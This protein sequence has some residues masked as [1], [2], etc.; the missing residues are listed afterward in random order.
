MSMIESQQ[1]MALWT[2]YMGIAA[3]IGITVGIIGTGLIFFTFWETRKGTRAA[4]VNSEAYIW[5]ERGRLSF[6]EDKSGPTVIAS[7]K[8][9]R[10]RDPILENTGKS[11]LTLDSVSYA[12]V[13]VPNYDLAEGFKSFDI[14]RM[15]I[16][17][18]NNVQA[19]D[20]FAGDALDKCEYFMVGSITYRSLGKASF[21][22]FFCLEVTRR[23]NGHDLDPAWISFRG[24]ENLPPD[25]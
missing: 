23:V 12:Y 14:S 4:Q 13:A 20:I 11:D 10:P 15:T 2:R 19:K 21:K 8:P 5:N 16:L 9:V 22:S 3:I 25:T 17:T 18:R 1:A 7:G 24:C 6:G